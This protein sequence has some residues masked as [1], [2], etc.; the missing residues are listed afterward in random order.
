MLLESAV[1]PQDTHTVLGR[2]EWA[3]Q[4]ELFGQIDTDPAPTKFSLGYICDFFLA[5]HVKL[6]IGRLASRYIVQKGL[7]V[8]YCSDP[9]LVHD[10]H[11]SQDL[12]S[13]LDARGPPTISR[14]RN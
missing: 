4:D 10:L 13:R 5:E 2:A 11:G 9:N 14:K 3:N 1:V 12:L 8:A 7:D 6:G